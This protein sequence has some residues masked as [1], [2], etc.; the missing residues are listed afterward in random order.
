MLASIHQ[1]QKEAVS[2]KFRIIF[3]GN[4]YM[5]FIFGQL[6]MQQ[7]IINC[8]EQECFCLSVIEC[9]YFL[10]TQDHS[11][12][13]MIQKVCGT[14]CFVHLK[15]NTYVLCH[16]RLDTLKNMFQIPWDPLLTIMTKASSKKEAIALSILYQQS[17]EGMKLIT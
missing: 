5:F 1:C 6:I 15:S 11:V 4:T 7:M 14:K 17:L 12:S 2:Q 9:F 13:L 3:C 8:L 16:A 10:N